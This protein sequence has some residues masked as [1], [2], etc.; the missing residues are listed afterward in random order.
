MNPDRFASR[1]SALTAAPS[2]R[3][4][5]RLVGGLGLTWLLGQG[6]APARKKHKTCAKAGQ[7][8]G[9]H[10]KQCC[11]G[12]VKDASGRCARRCSP[13]SCPADHLCLPNGVCQR[14]T[15]TCPAGATDCAA[16]LE[17]SMAAGGTVY[18]CPGLYQGDLVVGQSVTVIGAGQ[19]DDPVSNTILQGSGTRSVVRIDADTVVT[20]TVR[21]LRI[22]GGGGGPGAGLSS[23]AGTIVSLI[24]CTITG[25][26]STGSS[27]GGGI[28]TSAGTRLSLTGTTITGNSSENSGGGI[29][30]FAGR[31]TITK[32]TIT[33]NTAVGTT[34]GGIYTDGGTVTLD[35]A[36][37][38]TG[39]GARPVDPDSGGGIFL[40]TDFNSDGIVE[41]ASPANVTG[42]TP[43]NCGGGAVPRCVD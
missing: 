19:G 37:R 20:A 16:A 13:T 17:A 24:D 31:V 22:T 5:V 27:G 40:S 21:N 25:N 32:S 14:C 38:V 29:K 8:P 35:A 1:L 9:K 3:A 26:H 28:F 7:K 42:N 39:N 15:V 10:R 11:K 12:L 18:V 36:S 43:D 41:L 4:A 34:G 6:N 23:S 33:G 30:N 2:R